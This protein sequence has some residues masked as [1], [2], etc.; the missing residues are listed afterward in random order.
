VTPSPSVLLVGSAGSRVFEKL[1]GWNVSAASLLAVEDLRPELTPLPELVV[2]SAPPPEAARWVSAVRAHAQLSQ[3]PV[4]AHVE[5]YEPGVESLDV[6]AVAVGDVQ[7]QRKL[8][9]GLKARLAIVEQDRY[10]RRLESWLRFKERLLRE[11]GELESFVLAARSI[12]ESVSDKVAV[13]YVHAPDRFSKAGPEGVALAISPSSETL[14]LEAFDAGRPVERDGVSV[15]PAWSD[16]ERP[17]GALIVSAPLDE[18]ERGFAISLTD[19]L[20]W[21]LRAR[22][23]ASALENERAELERA[24]LDRYR[25]LEQANKRLAALDEWK[26]E[27]LGMVSHDARAPLQVL[28]GHGRLLLEDDLP[29]DARVGVDAMVRMGRKILAMMESALDFARTTRGAVSFEPRP[30]DIAEV[31]RDVAHDLFI[32]SEEKRIRLEVKAPKTLEVN[33]DELKLKQVLQNLI[34][35]ALQHGAGARH[36]VLKCQSVPSSGG[37][38][39]KVSI[40]DDGEGF[41]A[42]EMS[43]LFDRYER[44]GVGKGL[45]ICRELVRAHGG[46]IWA[47]HRQG[48]GSVLAFT[49]P[50]LV[51]ER[52]RP[53]QRETTLLL[54]D[55]DPNIRRSFSRIL[56]RH[57][58]IETAQDGAEAVAKAKALNPDLMLVD[59]F[60]PKKDGL[61]AIRE[62]RRDPALKKL[63]I[64]LMSARA[65]ATDRT[66]G[67]ELLEVELVPK[68]TPPEEL[69]KRVRAML[70]AAPKPSAIPD[71]PVGLLDRDGVVARL[72]E[73]QARAQRY[74]RPLSVAV[75]KPSAPVEGA[76]QVARKVREK[77][78]APDLIAHLGNGVL[79]LVLP[80]TVAEPA[81]A[82]ANR[83]CAGLEDEGTAYVATVRQVDTEVGAAELLQLLE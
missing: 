43:D 42:G 21:H 49:V 40:E 10:Q 55:D 54:A 75:L 68:L 3:L 5:K 47:E 4:V 31:A 64:I 39:V 7:L 17:L 9:A 25:E 2:V 44:D 72:E 32:L 50:E 35:N 51:R 11:K 78:R 53:A 6:D 41:A 81:Q 79:V 63:P 77:M 58:R 82:L 56:G 1:Q 52:T 66:Q 48:G 29:G 33:G 67:E 14:V 28:L 34:V 15:F 22:H 62:I 57:W 30:V 20:Q 76:E 60:M 12:A 70:A 61:D 18:R 19:N 71:A 65:E 80:E 74:G 83:L 23:A 69:I 13:V 38:R 46:E 37:P 8:F 73:E 26:D 24:Y 27:M 16:A 59:L 45:S 36:V